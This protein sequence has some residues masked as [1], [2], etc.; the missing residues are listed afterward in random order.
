VQYV[1]TR[2]QLQSGQLPPSEWGKMLAHSVTDHGN[3]Y[4]MMVLDAYQLGG[5][6]QF[7]GTNHFTPWNYDRHVP[8]AFYGTPFKPGE[9]HEAV[10]PVDLAVTFAS[11]A[12]VNRPSAAVGRVLVEALEPQGRA[13][14]PDGQK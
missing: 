12:G 13:S 14:A 4:V 10:E 6:G 8:L 7:A 1:Y 11:L 3:W 5:T 2:Q 9:Y